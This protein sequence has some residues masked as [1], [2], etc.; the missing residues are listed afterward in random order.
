MSMLAIHNVP[1]RSRCIVATNRVK[2]LSSTLREEFDTSFLFYDGSTGEL[3]GAHDAGESQISLLRES[4]AEIL[5]IAVN[6]QPHIS[7]RSTDRYRLVL[8]IQ[9]VD[10]PLLVAIGDLPAVARSFQD[11]RLEQARLRKW[12]QSVH[13][14]LSFTGWPL[15]QYRNDKPYHEQL[16]TL[17]EA[18]KELTDLLGILRI[19][20]DSS[21]NPHRILQR[22]AAVLSVQTLIWVPPGGEEPLV[23]EGDRLLSAQDCSEL[24]RR[25]SKSPEWDPSGYLILND[26]QSCGLGA[27][28]PRIINLMAVSVD[29]KDGRGWLIA[30][31][32]SDATTAANRSPGM[33]GRTAR[34]A[35]P[36]TPPD[37]PIRDR[38]EVVPFRRIDAVVLIP[39]GSLLGLQ[40]RSSRR[41]SHVQEL[42]AGLI[43]SLTAAIDAKDSYTCGHSERVARVAVELGRELELS[44]LELGDVYLGGLLHDIGKIGVPDSVLCKCGPLTAEEFLQI[45]QHVLIGCRI[46]ADFREIAHLLPLVLSHHERYDGMGYPHGLSGEAIPLLARV[47]A[48][49]DGYDAMNTSRPYR[50][51]LIRDRIEESLEEGKNRQW[52]GKVVDAFFRARER[53][54]SVHQRG[55]GDSAWFALS[56]AG[57]RLSPGSASPWLRQMRS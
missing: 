22:V 46:L 49:A 8:P 39:F 45:R 31:N 7:L 24:A 30:L 44:E 56:S 12:L 25:L 26:L 5:A 15:S 34:A 54:Y 47:L 16:K 32:K 33:D 23:I 13:S 55:I 40:S 4:T 21:K 52:D 42:F 11:S 36:A 29:E 9:E 53:I 28:F 57:E 27:R 20:G 51:A 38:L 6:G 17:L 50:D 10:G 1:G 3:L 41:Q 43:R 19:P 14:R 2:A 37:R 48:V 18:S 35:L